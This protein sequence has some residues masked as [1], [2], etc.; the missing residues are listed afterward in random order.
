MKKILAVLLAALMLFTFAACGGGNEDTTTTAADDTT[1]A[2]DDTTKADDTA[3]VFKI[4]GIGPTTG[5]AATYG[6]AVKNGA[7]IAVDEINALGGDI[8]FELNFQDDEHDA[9]KAVNAYNNLKDWGMQILMGTVTSTPCI[10]VATE[11]FADRIF[12]I[13]P[14]GSSVDILTGKDNVFQAC[15]TDP[16]QGTASAQYIKENNLAE[17]VA[18]IYKNDD[19]YSKGIYDTFAKE[20]EAQGLEIVYA[21]TFTKDTATDFSVQI[22]EAQKAG[23]TLMFLPIYFENASTILMQ[24]DSLGYDPTFF[25]VDGMDGILTLDGFDTSLAEGVLLLTPF[26]ADA[27]D[28]LTVNF[29]KKYKELYNEVPNQFA[30]DA[31]DSI[32]VIYEAIKAAKVTA[33]M[34]TAAICEALIAVMPELKVDGLTGVGMTWKATGEVSKAP[35]A[36]VIENGVYVGFKAE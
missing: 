23:A 28:D 13:T 30:A 17:K 19:A 33:D 26:S 35:K 14:S 21:G 4:G 36:V 15:F 11:T 29:V 20:A 5:G 31:Y 2:A 18:V 25:G 32:Y 3:A 7:Q 6:I 10:A 9:E 27:T 24:A 12:E 1:A 22:G 34:D 8:K 16:N